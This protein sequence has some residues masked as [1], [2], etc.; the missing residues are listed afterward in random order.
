MGA[1]GDEAF[2]CRALGILLADSQ[3][4]GHRP[5]RDLS[6]KLTEKNRYQNGNVEPISLGAAAVT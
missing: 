6:S 4:G 2:S 1:L 5:V 3:Y